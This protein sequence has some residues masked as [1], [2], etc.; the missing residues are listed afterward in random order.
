VAE[1]KDSGDPTVCQGRPDGERF[2]GWV[3]EENHCSD[4]L[5][6]MMYWQALDGGLPYRGERGPLAPAR[7]DPVCAYGSLGR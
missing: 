5:A 6:G 2:V 4:F 3:R 7:V 1:I